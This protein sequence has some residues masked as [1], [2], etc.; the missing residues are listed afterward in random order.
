MKA[1]WASQDSLFLVLTRLVSVE[2]AVG[3]KC[4]NVSV[5][6]VLQ[7]HIQLHKNR[8]QI[9]FSLVLPLSTVPEDF[10][11]WNLTGTNRTFVLLMEPL[12]HS[13]IDL[14]LAVT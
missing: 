11:M 14:A 1:S 8:V 10:G 5:F 6:V 2:L 9:T 13:V 3:Q 4:H 12:D 7:G